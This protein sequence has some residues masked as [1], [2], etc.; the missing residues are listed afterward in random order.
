MVIIISDKLYIHDNLIWMLFFAATILTIVLIIFFV[1]DID[2]EKTIFFTYF[3][4]YIYIITFFVLIM[5]GLFDPLHEN[6]YTYAIIEKGRRVTPYYY[7]LSPSKFKMIYVFFFIY[8][9]FNIFFIYLTFLTKKAIPLLGIYN[10]MFFI[11]ILLY[12][13]YFLLVF[14]FFLF[15]LIILIYL[16]FRNWDEY[17]S[18]K[19]NIQI[20]DYPNIPLFFH[21]TTVV[22]ALYITLKYLYKYRFIIICLHVLILWLLV[23]A[24]IYGGF[25]INIFQAFEVLEKFFFLNIF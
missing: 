4:A 15:C 5:N 1:M 17:E 18:S 23:F 8:S 7:L 19:I 10:L 25:Y 12:L 2:D 3:Y 21:R 22:I 20:I 13:S 6:Y 16:F 11:S 9:I 24:G 14:I